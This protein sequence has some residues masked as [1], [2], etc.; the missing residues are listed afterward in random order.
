M[1]YAKAVTPV[2]PPVTN[3]LNYN[4]KKYLKKVQTHPQPVVVLA[5]RISKSI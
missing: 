2:V 5:F 1:A 4:E 3:N